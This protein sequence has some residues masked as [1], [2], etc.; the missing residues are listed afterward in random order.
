MLLIKKCIFFLLLIT[1]YSFGLTYS[2]TRT[3]M[4]TPRINMTVTTEMTEII[5]IWASINGIFQTRINPSVNK[6]N[7][8]LKEILKEKVISQTLLKEIKIINN[9][10]ANIIMLKDKVSK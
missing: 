5:S 7:Q 9:D 1:T 6:K 4:I 3:D 10:I 8:L 2:L